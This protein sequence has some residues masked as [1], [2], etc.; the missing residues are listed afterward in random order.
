MAETGKSIRSTA[1]SYRDVVRHYVMGN[2]DANGNPVVT[3]KDIDQLT[4]KI[5]AM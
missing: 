1:N 3:K 5:N 4:E 2:E